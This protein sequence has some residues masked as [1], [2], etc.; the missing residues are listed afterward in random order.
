MPHLSRYWLMLA[1]R[2]FER[3][4]TVSSGIYRYADFASEITSEHFSSKRL[5]AKD[6]DREFLRKSKLDV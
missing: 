6:R 2:S 1:Q 4:L 5:P 3:L